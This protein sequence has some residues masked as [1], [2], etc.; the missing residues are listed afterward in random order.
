MV[1]R[2]RSPTARPARSILFLKPLAG[3][4]GAA[5]L[6]ASPYNQFPTSWS[7]DGRRLAFTE[8]QPLS[9]ADIWVLDTAT[10]ERRP[11]VRTLFDE[12]WARFSPD[13]QW[14]AYM[15]NESGRWEV[16]VRAAGG[17]G[18]RVRVSAAGGVWPC[19]SLDG[20]S[21]FFSGNGQTMA[22]SIRTA[23]RL[24]VSTPTVI[25]GADAMVL[26]GGATAGDRLLVRQ[27]GSPPEAHAEL[28]VV[29]EW[30]TELGVFDAPTPR[31]R[32]LRS[33]RRQL[34]WRRKHR[35]RALRAR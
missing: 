14:L 25:P 34:R 13:G 32:E 27:A 4:G 15:S 7:G 24:A 22:S 29:L 10:G 33:E 19:W 31:R 35:G 5:P 20:R 21:L 8:F 12:T 16:Y 3:D 1:S 28:R 9:G 11:V 2:S 30:F 17:E 18:P 23:P 6:L 26:A